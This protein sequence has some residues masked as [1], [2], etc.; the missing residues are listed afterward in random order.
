MPTWIWIVIGLGAAAVLAVVAYGA[1]RVRRTRTLRKAFGPEYDRALETGSDRREAEAD[2]MKRKERRE[3]FD[4]R[5]LLPYA[6]DGYLEMWATA[7]STFV[8]DPEGALLEAERL[9]RAV[10]RERGY[11]IDSFD[12]RAADLSVDYPEL[13]SRYREA[14]DIARGPSSTEDLRKAMQDYRTMF[15]E[16]VAAEEAEELEPAG[17]RS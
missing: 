8:D 11:P 4:I 6:R 14:R 2:L 9:V 12:Q 7:Q 15:R 5:P 3:E 10:M 16:L 1:W 17:V 13:V